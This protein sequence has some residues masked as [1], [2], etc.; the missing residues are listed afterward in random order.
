ME[1]AIQMT[2]TTGTV[3]PVSLD[4]LITIA[5][6][7]S[8]AAQVLSRGIFDFLDGGAGDE[9]TLRAN[10]SVFDAAVLRPRV[11]RDV[12]SI[13]ATTTVLGA[14]VALPILL[15]PA[16]AHRMYHE[17]GEL[18]CAR[19]AV[20]LG[21]GIVASTG[22]SFTLEDMAAVGPEV[23]WFQVYCYKDRS[24]TRVLLE[25]A[26]AAGYRAICVTLDTPRHGRRLR[27]VRNHF[28][29][30]SEI[31]RMNLEGV[32]QGDVARTGDVSSYVRDNYDASLSW[33]DLEWLAT[34]SGLPLILK[35]VL[36]PDDARM[37]ADAGVAGVI[38]SNHGGRQLDGAPATLSALPGVVEAAGGRLEVYLDGGIRRGTDVVKAIALGARA[39]FVGRP[40]LWGLA[41]GGE[42]GVTRV[43]QLLR[44]EL[45]LTMTL[46]GAPALTD[47]A[48]R[49]TLSD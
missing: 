49:A 9:I 11:L 22:A 32:S 20:G 2:G 33:R 29:V 23:R 43:L 13:N 39:V 41:V 18:A 27:N 14:P 31:H 40:Y 16:G 8:A 1:A 46:M 5:D 24:I 44:D 12:S 36:D 21:T 47:L 45:M 10:E 28:S 3:Q 26:A 42:R 17:D 7:R 19:A 34:V 30:P 35:G 6:F 48:G 15:A 25:R 37:A 4:E 38:V